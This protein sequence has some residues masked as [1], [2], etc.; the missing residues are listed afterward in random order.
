MELLCYRMTQ[1][2]FLYGQYGQLISFGDFWILCVNPD[3]LYIHA[4]VTA[5]DAMHG[6]WADNG[7]HTC[8]LLWAV[9][10]LGIYPTMLY[11][12]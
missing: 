10:Y 9:P 6:Q 7:D 4:V 2:F 12:E 11:L 8:I 5:Y 3:F 1:F